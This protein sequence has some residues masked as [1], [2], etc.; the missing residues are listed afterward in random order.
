M[1]SRARDKRESGVLQVNDADLWRGSD[2][3][4][5]LCR[6]TDDPWTRIFEEDLGIAGVSG[7]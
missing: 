2:D 6:E 7:R 1:V 3:V 4:T 5:C